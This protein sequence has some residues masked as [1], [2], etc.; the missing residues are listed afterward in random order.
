LIEKLDFDD[1]TF[2][3]WLKDYLRNSRYIKIENIMDAC[4]DIG[5]FEFLIIII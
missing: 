1:L 3:S 4:K 5:K 2:R